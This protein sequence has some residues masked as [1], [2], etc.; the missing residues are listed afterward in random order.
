[1]RLGFVVKVLGGGGLPS[2]DTRRWQ[3]DPGLG[4]SLDYL[5]KFSAT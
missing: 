4:T 2:H 1:M 3:S 5:V